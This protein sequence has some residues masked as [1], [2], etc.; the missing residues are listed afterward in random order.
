M[1]ATFAENEGDPVAGALFFCDGESLFG[2]YWGTK[3][4]LD[5][6]HFELCY[7]LPIEWA[8]QNGIKR[9]EAGAQGDHKL[10]RGFLPNPCYSAHW[11]EH[12]GLAESVYH[13]LEREAVGI[14]V[15]IA[16]IEEHSP[17]KQR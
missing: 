8:I 14:H 13:F 2:R 4:F 11:I 16:R 17:F 3:L 7:Y 5:C 15:A 6:M 10:K 12:Q 1:V 9:F